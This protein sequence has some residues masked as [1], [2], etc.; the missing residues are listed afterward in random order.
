MTHRVRLAGLVGLAGLAA[1]GA[2]LALAQDKPAPPPP[3]YVGAN[4]CKTC[5]MSKASGNAH[6]HWT[7]S[8]HAQA[9]ATLATPAALEIGKAKGIAKPQEDAACLRCHVTGHGQAAERFDKT[10]DPKQGI[11]CETCHGPG[12]AH[13]SA[14]LKAALGKKGAA[15]GA[16]EKLPEGEIIGRP[17]PDTCLTCHNAESPSYKGFCFR[18]RVVQILHHDPRKGRDPA[19]VAALKC[20]CEAPCKCQKSE[21]GGWP[22]AEEIAKAKEAGKK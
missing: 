20:G 5:H 10:F 3:K 18:E 9:F 7:E 12:G 11:S 21:C 15:D 22:T 1:L 13:A 16:P 17:S 2:G 6:G 8:K 4:K 14:R 19:E